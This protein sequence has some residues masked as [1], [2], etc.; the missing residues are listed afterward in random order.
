M[1]LDKTAKE[2]FES[3]KIQISE[4]GMSLSKGASIEDRNLYQSIL[5]DLEKVYGGT[6]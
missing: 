1:V 2:L 5:K 3:G 4:Q 6:K